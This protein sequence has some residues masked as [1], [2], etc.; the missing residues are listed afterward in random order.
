MQPVA[1]GPHPWIARRNRLCLIKQA[2]PHQ[3]ITL[4]KHFGLQAP[5]KRIER[6]F[7]QS[8]INNFAKL[9]SIIRHYSFQQV[10]CVTRRSKTVSI[11]KSR[12]LVFKL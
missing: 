11:G 6:S 1:Q 7:R 9:Q 2:S 5:K 3:Q 12:P 4:R 8:L 10:L